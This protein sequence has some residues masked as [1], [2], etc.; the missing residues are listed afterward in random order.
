[1]RNQERQASPPASG[2]TRRKGRKK[3]DPE[4][5]GKIEKPRILRFRTRDLPSCIH[6]ETAAVVRSIV[7]ERG[8]LGWKWVWRTGERAVFRHR[9]PVPVSRW[10]EKHRVVHLS[11]RPGPWRNAVTPY[12]AGIM[13]ASYF[14]SV[15]VISLMKCPQSGGT[16]GVHNCIAY[17][18]DRA[19][20]PVLYVYPDEP[21]AREN[22]RDRIIPMLH[23]SPRLAEYL[24][25]LSDDL[26]SL[27][28][29]LAH[30]TIYMAWS[31]SP[32]R[33]GNKPIRYLVLDELDKFQNTRREARSENL[34]EKRVITWGRRARIWKISTPTMVDGPIHAAF[35]KSE[36]R[37][38]YYV[39]CPECGCEQLMD[40]ERIMRDPEAG[41]PETVRSRRLAWYEC[42]HCQAR[43]TDVDRDMAV[44]AGLWRDEASG[45][46]LEDA[47]ER[48]RPIS[49]GFHLPAW[50]S[51]FVPLADIAAKALEYELT[52][53][54]A[55]YKDLQN[56]YKAEPWEERFE[57]RSENAI[58]ALCD[59]RPRG[60]VPGPL[61]PAAPG[62]PPRERV[63]CLLAGVDTQLRYFRYVIRAFGFGEEAESWLIQEG[64]APSLK[65][66]DDLF[67]HSSYP[68]ADGRP[69]LVRAA[70]IDAMGEPTRTAQ[71]YAW[72]A[73]NRGRV[74][75]SQG[76]H[77][78]STPVGY[79]PQEYFPGPKGERIKIPGG[80]LLHRVDTTLF[81]GVLA[82]RLAIRPQDP[83]A[84]HLHADADKML[85]L[86]AKEMVAEVWDPEK[87]L[88]DNPKRKP[89][90]AWDCEY[91]LWALHWMLG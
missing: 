25:G 54:M 85:E 21:T 3:T 27:R 46:A 32:A 1:M 52:Q 87:A 53:D 7:A 14:S 6:P 68:D 71:V 63:A 2:K 50:I 75:P 37:F 84:F 41:D 28:L 24:T 31:G 19:P 49:I 43:W 61:P 60:R 26:A 78:P 58:L 89:N 51:P 79:A 22:A 42:A 16:E 12:N 66:L 62:E 5:N 91:L 11:S 88:W 35:K 40:F 72:A 57:V 77:A 10:A 82:N 38:R 48:F 56:N 20:G 55:V 69:H 39:I 33:L 47:L 65:A 81:K 44:R 13:D 90:H 34:A 74:F 29:N 30:V 76:V 8:S 15:Q 36:I 83:G 86:Y 59:D 67:W 70:I 45:L 80:I 9:S 73:H 17:A 4:R 64:T 18:I 23:A